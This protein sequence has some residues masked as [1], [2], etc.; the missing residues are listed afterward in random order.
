MR[1]NV[2]GAEV[3]SGMRFCTSCGAPM[4][5]PEAATMPMSAADAVSSPAACSVCGE[6]IVPGHAFCTACGTPVASAGT[7]SWHEAAAGSEAASGA[8]GY[9]G[10]SGQVEASRTVGAASAA[11][12]PARTGKRRRPAVI[13]AIVVVVLLVL[14]GAGAGIFIAVSGGPAAAWARLTGSADEADAADEAAEE[15]GQ[16]TATYASTTAVAV[17]E[18]TL[19]VPEDLS[20]ERLTSYVVRVKQADDLDGVALDIT[21]M[22]RLSIDGTDGFTL[23]S[24]GDL[25]EGTY[26]LCIESADGTSLDLP[27]LV[28]D[29]SQAA[30]APGELVVTY[31][32]GATSAE[33][34]ARAGIYACFNDVLENVIATY[35]DAE[36]VSMWIDEN[37]Y[38]GWTAGTSY[39]EL[40][41]FGDGIE[42]LVVAFCT[43]P[44][45]GG[46]RTVEAVEDRASVYGPH[47]ED[48]TIEVW[49]YDTASDAA[50]CVATITPAGDDSGWPYL[51]YVE[52]A[53]TGGIALVAMGED[54]NG[55]EA[56]SCFGVDADGSFGRL[57]TAASDIER[58][59]TET[60]Y[61]LAHL[62]STAESSLRDSS[63]DEVSCKET[64]QTV[65]D[66]A[67][68]LSTL[69]GA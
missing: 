43:D 36:L 24:L 39:A 12:G 15:P 33:G 49:E 18:T 57:S 23:E 20:G 9:A 3:G 27:P 32:D 41:D 17:T 35:G 22:P 38:L 19:I 47:T 64:A 25:A 61:L 7:S 16:L 2:C 13:V 40:V 1:C 14:A 63:S 67:S 34:L 45:L 58:L 30:D 10:A 51:R 4:E 8:A 54:V 48:Y 65:K 42:R 60:T 66:L 55:N 69:A 62:G 50:V 31:P 29:A 6:P 21:E 28:L 46:S 59:T 37:L 68:Q 5:A 26:Q 11:D 53:D 56:L 52:N 44:E